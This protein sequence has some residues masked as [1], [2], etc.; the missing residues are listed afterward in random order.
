MGVDENGD[1]IVAHGEGNTEFSYIDKLD[2][3]PVGDERRSDPPLLGTLNSDTVNPCRIQLDSAG[4]VYFEVGG[5]FGFGGL[6]FS[7][8]PVKR[9]APNFHEPSGTSQIPPDQRDFSTLAHAGPDVGFAFDSE[10]NLYGLRPSGPSRVQKVDQFGFVRE[11]IRLGLNLLQPG[12]IAVNKASGT[13]YVTDGSFEPGVKDVHVFKAFRVP[14]SITGQFTGTTQT[15]GFV[16]GEVDLAEAGEE[17]TNC[18]F[19]YTTGCFQC[20]RIWRSEHR[21]V[22]RGDD[23]QRERTSQRQQLALTLE[24]PYYLPAGDRE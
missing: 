11:Y 1:L 22:R 12:D 5:G 6:K 9:Y 8:G 16:S 17:V 10:D 3:K 15:G 20:R 14:N 4:N 19:E 7:E 2:I 21:P 24:E 23:V 13:I 18:E